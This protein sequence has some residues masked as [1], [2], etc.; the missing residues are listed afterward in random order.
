MLK[1]FK[2]VDSLTKLIIEQRVIKL[3]KRQ[4]TCG[5]QALL[6]KYNYGQYYIKNF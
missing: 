4:C 1:T 6:P 5:R 2:I 3:H